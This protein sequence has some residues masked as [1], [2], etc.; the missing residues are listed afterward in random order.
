MHVCVSVHSSV[1]IKALYGYTQG[2]VK[3]YIHGV[4][5]SSA[6]A[7]VENVKTA[8]VLGYKGAAGRLHFMRLKD[9]FCIEL[10]TWTTWMLAPVYSRAR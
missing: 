9:S 4:I 8:S 10:L 3:K 5:C 2:L 1:S 6:T 7:G